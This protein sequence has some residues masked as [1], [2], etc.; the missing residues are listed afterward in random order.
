MSDLITHILPLAAG[1]AISPTILTLSVLILSGPHGKGRQA[2]FTVVNVGLMTA[3]AIFGTK[4]LSHVA[5]HKGG[6]SHAATE[7]IYV[8]LGIVLVLLAIREHFH[9]AKDTDKEDADN[10]AKS[11]GLAPARYAS[12]GVIV[13]ATNFTTMALFIPALREIA[14]STDPKGDRLLAGAV[15][16][17]LATITAWLPLLATIV[18][19][20]PATKALASIHD[21]TTKY[22]HQIVEV[23]LIGFG[24]YMIIKGF[25]AH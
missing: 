24:A 22:K 19:P 17:T 21:F 14:V 7:G 18:L 13:T 8:T 3:I 20:G 16:V 9:P 23:V 25:S 6:G 10:A 2:I 4:A 12:L 11:T 5:A 15:L 1:A